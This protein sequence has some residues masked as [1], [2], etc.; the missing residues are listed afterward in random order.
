M[1]AKLDLLSAGRFAEAYLL[2]L[3]F[4]SEAY[5]NAPE[6]KYEFKVTGVDVAADKVTVTVTLKRGG[7]RLK[8]GVNGEL[9]LYGGVAPGAFGDKPLAVEKITNATFSGDGD[10]ESAVIEYGRTGAAGEAKFFQPRIEAK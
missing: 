8:G 10:E 1:K 3:D 9:R 2:N 7:A 5:A 6:P 4:T